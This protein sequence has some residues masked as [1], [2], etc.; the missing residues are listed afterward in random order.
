MEGKIYCRLVADAVNDQLVRYPESTLKDIYKSFFQ[1]FWGP[2]HLLEDVGHA[3]KYFDQELSGMKGAGN[4]SSDPCGLGKRFFRAGLGCIVDGRVGA[5]EFF[6]AFLESS[7]GFSIPDLT[8]WQNEWQSI[9]EGI[10][11]HKARIAGFDLDAEFI[12]SRLEAG[13]YA[14]HHSDRY[15]T[16]YDPHYRILNI[17]FSRKLNICPFRK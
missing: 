2:G 11:V 17:E 14:I 9:L 3:R 12:K 16:E 1:D 10:H 6:E 7:R 15:R 8:F 13:N 4:R 5:D